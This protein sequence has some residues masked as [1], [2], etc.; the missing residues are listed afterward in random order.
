MDGYLSKPIKLEA[1]REMLEKWQNVSDSDIT[2]NNTLLDRAHLEE[3]A[4]GDEEFIREILQEFLNT[5]PHLLQQLQ[6]AVQ[7]GNHELL[8]H[9]AHTLKGSAR[10]IGAHTFA[11]TAFGLEQAGK[12]GRSHEVGDRLQN[13][14]AEWQRLERYIEQQLQCIAA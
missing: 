2:I 1:L 3:I 5:T 12:E 13:L 6:Q 7:E 8:R 11:E 4:G 14:L 10:A 9:T